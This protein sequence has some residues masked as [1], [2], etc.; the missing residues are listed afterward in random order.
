MMLHYAA[1]APVALRQV[2]LGLWRNDGLAVNELD[3]VYVPGAA[4]RAAAERLDG[5]TQLITR[6][7]RLAGPTVA[8]EGARAAAFEVPRLGVSILVL[9]VE[10]DER[11]WTGVF[12]F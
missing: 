5:Q 9:D 11:V 2:S 10:N 7:E 1:R 3:L 4:G 6:L 8:G 12:V